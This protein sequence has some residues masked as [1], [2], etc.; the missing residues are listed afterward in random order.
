MAWPQI[1]TNFR[2]KDTSSLSVVMVSGWLVG[3]IIKTVAFMFNPAAPR[4]LVTSAIGQCVADVIVLF[5]QV[6]LYPSCEVVRLMRTGSKFS[7][8]LRTRGFKSKKL[9]GREGVV[10]HVVDP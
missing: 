3:D 6:I 5:Q 7:N 9:N 4:V 1:Y 2:S 10:S 8:V